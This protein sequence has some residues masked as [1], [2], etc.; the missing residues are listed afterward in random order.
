MKSRIV[1][2]VNIFLPD[3]GKITKGIMDVYNLCH[4]VRDRTFDNILI[5]RL[6][7]FWKNLLTCVLSKNWSRIYCRRGFHQTLEAISKENRK[8]FFWFWNRFRRFISE[9]QICI[10]ECE[11]LTE[12]EEDVIEE[13]INNLLNLGI[14][15]LPTLKISSKAD[16]EDVAEIFVRVNSGGQNLTE[17]ILLKLWLLSM[18]MMSMQRLTGFVRNQE[19]RQMEPRLIRFFRLTLLI[20]FE[21]LLA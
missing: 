7:E 18:I 2:D 10:H 20:W 1:C 15:S 14:Y 5:F 12:E 13:N 6:Y 17:K 11:L 19:Y 4:H 3:I 16:E 8:V 21:C 9:K